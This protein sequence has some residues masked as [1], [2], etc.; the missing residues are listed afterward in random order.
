MYSEHAH[1]RI[2]LC[3]DFGMYFTLFI[4]M[5]L[6]PFAL[7]GV[8]YLS[9][10]YVLKKKWPTRYARNT[11]NSIT[12]WGTSVVMLL[13]AYD[14]VPKVELV[15]SCIYVITTNMF[16]LSSQL[17]FFDVDRAMTGFIY[18]LVNFFA[19]IPIAYVNSLYPLLFKPLPEYDASIDEQFDYLWIVGALA[20]FF[21][22]FFYICM[23]TDESMPMVTVAP[24]P[25]RTSAV[26]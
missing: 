7:L 20:S 13:L 11:C 19:L 14:T 5:V 22:N 24:M 6:T 4:C 18:G 23:A 10:K 15:F 21:G 3:A 8:G 9:D 12:F 25:P 17:N 2:S 16:Y 1:M 26:K